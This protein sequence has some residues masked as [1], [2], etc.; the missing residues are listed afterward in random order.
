MTEDQVRAIVSQML[1][2]G[3]YS[4]PKVPIHT[5]NG[6]D[7]FKIM[8]ANI[9]G[10]PTISGSI[11]INGL[12]TGSQSTLASGMSTQV[13]FSANSF[14]NGITWD[15][16]GYQFTI[17]TAGQ[18]LIVGRVNYSSAIATTTYSASI[19]INASGV[20]T[21]A[22]YITGNN[23]IGNEV[24]YLV[25]LAVGDNITLYVEQ[26]SGFTANFAAAYLAVAKV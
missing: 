25:N 11:S 24:T 21:D 1:Q 8:Y 16:T 13:Q 10:T 3:Q 9:T 20:A 2:K 12:S 19:N 6:I 15:G 26:S 7:S 4:V 23:T 18:Y 17:V 5:H 14:S 22:R